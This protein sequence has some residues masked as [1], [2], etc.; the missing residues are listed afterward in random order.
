MNR[1][2]FSILGFNIYWYSI[3]ILLGIIVAYFLITKESSKHNIDKNI[4]ND[5]IFY[6]ILVGLLGARLYYVIFNF[7]YYIS[8]PLEIFAVWN[9]GL[10]IHGGL[11]AGSIFIYFYSKKKNINFLRILDIVAPAV[12]IAQAFGRWGNFFNQEAHGGK[13]ALE[14]LKS[15]H[16]P[17]FVINGM[18]IDGVYYYPTFFFESIGC[19]IGAIVIILIRKKKNI[20]LGIS[21]GLY[22]IWYGVLRFFIESLRTDSLMFLNLK[23][24]QIVSIISIIIGIVL[25]FTS[26]KKEKY[27]MEE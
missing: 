22:L 10:A 18:K 26:R 11:I 16:I 24:A 3:F 19:L 6:G 27:L 1:V 2:A 14:V 8:N 5:M 12:M 21:T 15:M 20:K 7:D 4:I 23:M 25:I 9:G 17:K 13:V